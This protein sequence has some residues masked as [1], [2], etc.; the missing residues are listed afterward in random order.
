MRKWDDVTPEGL[1]N[2]I[3]YLKSNYDPSLSK[4]VIELFQERMQDD[5]HVDPITLNSLM[6]HVFSL[7]I[8][9]KSAD[10]A[11]GLKIIKGKYNR[12]DT[13]ERD[14]CATAIIVIKRRQGSSLEDA[15]AD[16]AEHMKTS[17]TTIKR[18]YKNHRDFIELL[19]DEHLEK[20]FA[21]Q[22]PPL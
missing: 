17:D 13:I 6:K 5:I 22:L 2:I 11:F 4:K 7:I 19:P 1:F 10:Q 8:E 20:M 16:A 14:M 18:S 3:E 21:G 9:G 15:V 12:E